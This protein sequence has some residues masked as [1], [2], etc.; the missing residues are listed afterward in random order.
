LQFIEIKVSVRLTKIT[1]KLP[2]SME[3]DPQRTHKK[4]NAGA[5]FNKKKKRKLE[6]EEPSDDPKKRNPKAF[7][8]QVF[9]RKSFSHR[10]CGKS[11]TNR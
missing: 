1:Y 5:K 7:S 2:G 8:F 9:F 6:E 3:A 11:I 4:R 10:I